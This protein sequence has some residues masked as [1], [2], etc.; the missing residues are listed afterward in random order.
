VV[1]DGPRTSDSLECAS[2]VVEMVFERL[3]VLLLLLA[4]HDGVAHHLQIIRL[5]I[6]QAVR[7]MIDGSRPTTQRNRVLN[8]LMVTL[9][10]PTP[11]IR[12][13]YYW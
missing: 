5:L 1:V 9:D 12:F 4:P 11:Y 6:P 13:C 3:H 10:T 2:L 8:A 7:K